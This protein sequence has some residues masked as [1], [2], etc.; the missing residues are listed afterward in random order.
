MV[1]MKKI[2]KSLNKYKILK[3]RL[4]Y[5]VVILSNPQNAP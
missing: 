1:V 5:V 4:N 2:L 3:I